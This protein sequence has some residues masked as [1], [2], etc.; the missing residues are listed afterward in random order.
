MT[1][2]LTTIELQSMEWEVHLKVLPR[3]EPPG[4]LEFCFSRTDTEGARRE[5]FWRVSDPSLQSLAETGI[6][7]SSDLLRKQLE[8]A[9]LQEEVGAAH[10]RLHDQPTEGSATR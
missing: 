6:D 7:V 3:R 4:V 5:V 1:M 8:S 10:P 9:L 2:Y